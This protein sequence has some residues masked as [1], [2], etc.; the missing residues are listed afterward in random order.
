MR[1]PGNRSSDEP[2]LELLDA[3]EAALDAF[4]D[5]GVSESAVLDYKRDLPSDVS[6]TVAAMAN[7]DGGTI[8]LGI[9]EDPTTKKPANRPGVRM[10]DPQGA[11]VGQV[12]SLL[13]PVPELH[14]HVVKRADGSS[15]AVVITSPSTRR[16]VL[17]RTKS[18]LVR[19]G[20]QTVPPSRAELERLIR[21]ELAP[22][23]DADAAV[24]AT[25]G[26]LNMVGNPKTPAGRI[27]VIASMRPSGRLQVPLDVDSDRAIKRAAAELLIGGWRIVQDPDTTRLSRQESWDT[28]GEFVELKRD[29]AV[30]VRFVHQ[31]VGWESQPEY[32]IVASDLAVDIVASLLIP[33]RMAEIDDRLAANGWAASVTLTDYE[34]RRLAFEAPKL[35]MRPSTRTDLPKIVRSAVLLEP[36]DAVGLA[37]RVVNDVARLHGGNTP[38]GWVSALPA[39]LIARATNRLGAFRGRLGR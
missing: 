37:V 38:T 36:S 39:D 33:F 2:F 1:T 20:D 11:V 9:E 13:E 27:A 4:L 18:V 22:A 21:R 34:G 7:T 6:E 8:I 23:V 14:T 24:N 16:L 15:Y 28:A 3:D 19:V 5:L 12:R 17:H 10:K 30:L 32:V 35:S 25:A 26:A 29:G 31:R